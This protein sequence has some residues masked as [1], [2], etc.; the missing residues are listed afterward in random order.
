M[1]SSSRSAH[2][3]VAVETDAIDAI[4]WGAAAEADTIGEQQFCTE[5]C[6]AKDYSRRRMRGE[7]AERAKQAKLL[8][9][10]TIS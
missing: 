6:P 3:R 9:H 5:T 10:Y 7:V 2:K 8:V 4:A 1:G